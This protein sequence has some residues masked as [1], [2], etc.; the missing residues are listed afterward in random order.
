ML[1]RARDSGAPQLT[2][3]VER[4]GGRPPAHRGGRCTRPAAAPGRRVTSTDRRA[5]LAGWVVAVVDLDA[6]AL[7]AHARTDMV[8]TVRDSGDAAA[9]GRAGRAASSRS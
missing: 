4:D 3:P 8:A 1:D 9:G 5:R 7:D 2:A 6:L